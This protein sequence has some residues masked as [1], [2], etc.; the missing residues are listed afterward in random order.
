MLYVL[1]H[2][3]NWI[4]IFTR[5]TNIFFWNFRCPTS[6][7][8]YTRIHSTLASTTVTKSTRSTVCWNQGLPTAIHY[9][10]VLAQPQTLI[11]RRCISQHPNNSQQRRNKDQTDQQELKKL[12]G[13]QQGGYR[14]VHASRTIQDEPVAVDGL[15][16]FPEFYDGPDQVRFGAKLL[17]F[18]FTH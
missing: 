4:S 15:K 5:L 2:V 6:F 3:I 9:R 12:P 10:E 11:S 17:F 1:A 8:L 18:S 13:I 7:V 16:D 14:N